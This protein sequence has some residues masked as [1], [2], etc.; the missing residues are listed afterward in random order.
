MH[1]EAFM[2]G[3][4]LIIG[5]T[6]RSCQP[7]MAKSYGLCRISLPLRFFFSMYLS[8]WWLAGSHH[9]PLILLAVNQKANII[10][11][12]RVPSGTKQA[13]LAKTFTGQTRKR[14]KVQS[15]TTSVFLEAEPR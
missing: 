7:L 15:L 14:F 8:V 4:I 12:G 10:N 1:P 9:S 11:I 6:A 3:S 13:P 5:R 2:A